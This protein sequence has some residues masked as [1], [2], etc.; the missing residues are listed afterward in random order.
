MQFTEG[1]TTGDLLAEITRLEDQ[2]SKLSLQLDSNHEII[3][4]LKQSLAERDSR[5]HELEST[6]VVT[7][8]FLLQNA[9]DK[10]HQCKSQIKDG[11]VE[12]IIKPVLAQIR[13]QILFIQQ[14]T[15]ESKDFINKTKQ[16][17]EHN[18]EASTRLINKSPEQAW[19]YI[20]KN[21]IEPILSL[22]HEVIESMHCYVK[23]IQNFIA[24]KII[25]SSKTFYEHCIETVLALPSQSQINFQ[26]WV[27]EPVLLT[28]HRLSDSSHTLTDASLAKLKNFLTRLKNL[29][30]EGFA[31]ITEQVKKSPFWDGK[32]N[33]EAFS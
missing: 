10:I 20:E 8:K 24:Q 31:D 28:L 25:P 15:D 13:Q 21:I 12:K 6:L 19:L 30:D 14:L 7:P 29:I 33:I 5:I 23:I 3:I 16:I 9:L 27:I 11:I 32:R 2:L 1:A 4:M 26:I 22:T 17:I 18:I